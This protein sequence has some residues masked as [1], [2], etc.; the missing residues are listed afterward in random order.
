MPGRQGENKTRS[1]V[2]LERL[3][4]KH[5]GVM[6]SRFSRIPVGMEDV[7]LRENVG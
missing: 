2:K 6:T 5:I 3:G 4:A 7:F 1:V